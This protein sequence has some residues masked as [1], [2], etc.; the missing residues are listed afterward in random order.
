MVQL[1]SVAVLMWPMASMLIFITGLPLIQAA[2]RPSILAHPNFRD[3]FPWIVLFSGAFCAIAYYLSSIPMRRG[4]FF[5]TD[6]P[7]PPL[8]DL[9]VA[10]ATIGTLALG[11]GLILGRKYGREAVAMGI[12]I[13]GP[14]TVALFI[15]WAMVA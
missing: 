9:A 11:I 10:V 13:V 8:L 12:D 5:D 2:L 6:V 15:G 1:N 3:S 4:L 7:S 14:V